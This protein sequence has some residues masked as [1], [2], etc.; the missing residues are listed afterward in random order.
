MSQNQFSALLE[1]YIRNSSYSIK[2]LSEQTNINRTVLQKY[3][4]GDRLPHHYSS[5]AQIAD[6]LTLSID[7]KKS[8]FE[9][10]KIQKVGIHQYQYLQTL[11]KI[12][13]KNNDYSHLNKYQ[14]HIDYHFAQQQHFADNKNSL[15]AL[16]RY[17]IHKTS[18]EHLGSL[19]VY[20][21]LDHDIY[22]ILYNNLII[23][24]DLNMHLLIDI[25]LEAENSLFNI[26]QLEKIMPFLFLNNT[27][28]KCQYGQSAFYKNEF[29]FPYLLANDKMGLLISSTLTSGI[30][31]SNQES[32]FII[33]HFLQ[34]YRM[35]K[36]FHNNI[37]P[38]ENFVHFDLKNTKKLKIR[39]F[40]YEPYII[41]NIDQYIFENKYI[42]PLQTKNDILNIILHYKDL[43]LNHIKEGYPFSFYFTKKGLKSFFETGS[44]TTVSSSIFKPFTKSEV[45]Q[46]LNRMALLATA[47][48]N[49]HFYLIDDQK[50][51]YSSQIHIIIADQ[52]HIFPVLINE[53]TEKNFS[54]I[55]LSE[56]ITCQSFY[57]LPALLQMEECCYSL[58]DS[59]EFLKNFIKQHS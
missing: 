52:Y 30:L 46:I 54:Y 35:A 36:I 50:L 14:Y 28:I 11:K 59:L 26:K 20:I 31:L 6:K 19:K 48:D 4:S 55:S 22:Q 45:I 47:Y 44:V 40:N 12:V 24:D 16:I 43:Y 17:F 56:P 13:E 2:K 7:Q 21:P 41:P 37:F 51:N 34:Q 10:Y 49:Y 39:I 58:Q 23:N 38:D 27:Q 53:N 32:T 8:L 3:I 18:K 57:S 9:A 33:T 1:F 15:L 5:I 42:G 25:A 29:S